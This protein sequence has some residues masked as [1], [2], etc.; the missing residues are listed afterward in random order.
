[1]NTQNKPPSWGR[2]IGGA[3]NHGAEGCQSWE[4]DFTRHRVLAK[5]GGV[6]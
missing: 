5:E 6:Y 2:G 4:D 1:M 3:E